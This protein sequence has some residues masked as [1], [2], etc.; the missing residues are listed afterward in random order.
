[1][2]KYLLISLLLSAC[3][4]NSITEIK[5]NQVSYE[6]QSTFFLPDASL[7]NIQ[8]NIYDAFVRSIMSRKVDDLSS[9]DL[10][11]HK[12]YSEKKQNLILYWISYLQYYKAI[13]YLQVKDDE[14]AEKE[15]D[16]GVEYMEN[17]EKKN[18]EDFALLS[19]LKSFSLQFVSPVKVP[20]VAGTVKKY[21]E[22]AITL[23]TLN[24]RAYYV[25]GSNDFYTPEKYGGGK[26]AEKY[27]LKAISLPAQ[28]VKN[29][30]LP[31]WG[32]EEA[33]DMLIKLYMKKEK[34]D[35]AKKYYQ[36]GIETFPESYTISQLA[37]KLVGK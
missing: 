26:E 33:Y 3:D 7:M 29:A 30:Y 37:G 27:L 28:K 15:I 11:L 20:F 17:M 16:K 13:Y 4:G 10:T 22:T 23:D 18:S 21:G 19:M 2:K 34:W 12:L 31:S 24:L 9:L 35:L 14:T 8:K 36:K 25:C 32:K 5:N 6:S 1:M